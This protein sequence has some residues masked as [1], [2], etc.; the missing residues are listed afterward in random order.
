MATARARPASG[1]SGSGGGGGAASILK[2]M[3][4]R[5]RTFRGDAVNQY[6]DVSNVG[7]L[8]LDD[9]P[10]A[11]A[12]VSQNAFDPATQRPSIVRVIKCIVPGWADID[13][14]DTIQDKST[15]FFYLVESAEA[16]PG[17]GYR[18][19][20]RILT[21]RQRSGVSVAGERGPE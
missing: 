4:R 12:E 21:L 3:N 20:R 19:P 16:E 9:V 13:L 5:L 15:G 11:L 6:G 10:A 17:L 1:S 8:F 18:P 2:L 7:Q 14:D